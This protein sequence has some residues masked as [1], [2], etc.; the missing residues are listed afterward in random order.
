MATTADAADPV[1]PKPPSLMGFLRQ[2]AVL[3]VIWWSGKVDWTVDENKRMLV[4]GFACVMA[5]LFGMIQLASS[6]VRSKNDTARVKEPGQSQY[7]TEDVLA[8]DGSVSVCQYDMA[9]L[10]EARQVLI[11]SAGMTS[12]MFYMWGYTQPLL[13]M[14]VVQPLQ[15]FDNAAIKLHLFGADPAA[16]PRP[17]A[18]ANADNP[19]AKWAEKKKAEAAEREKEAEKK[20]D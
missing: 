13:M 11:M 14:S 9:K 6:R 19:I 3:P 18:S 12:F 10:S 4:L 2:V 15:L 8:S 17:W 16:H 1:L 5:M 7:L 20:K